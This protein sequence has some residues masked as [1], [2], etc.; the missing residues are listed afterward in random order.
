MITYLNF[1]D[2]SRSLKHTQKRMAHLQNTRELLELIKVK[3]ICKRV[4]ECCNAYLKHRT[5]VDNCATASPLMKE[6]YD[7][8]Y[9]ELDLSQ[10]LALRPKDEV[11]CAHFS[12]KQFTLH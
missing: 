6:A 11:E 9:I 1:I 8:M 12:G 4:L 3:D 10:N 2:T 7:G 5:Y